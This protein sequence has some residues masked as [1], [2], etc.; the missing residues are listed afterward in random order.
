VIGLDQKSEYALVQLGPK[1]AKY[2]KEIGNATK[3][4]IRVFQMWKALTA[5]AWSKMRRQG[6]MFRGEISWDALKD[7]T[8][9]KQKAAIINQDSGR[10]KSSVVQQ[11]IDI[12]DEGRELWIGAQMVEYGQHAFGIGGR[13][14]LVW[15]AQDDRNAVKVFD[16]FLQEKA[17]KIFGGR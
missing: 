12:R 17:D 16:G 15:T 1:F 14:V 11:K 8:R 5:N 7:T 6:G 3:P 13:N 9:P 2:R 10:L 4:F